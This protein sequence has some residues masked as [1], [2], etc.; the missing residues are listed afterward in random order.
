MLSPAVPGPALADPAW[1]AFV[2]DLVDRV[3]RLP[4]EGTLTV[5]APE[6]MARP[7]KPRV[8]LV[9][10]VLGQR[11]TM[12]PAW[13][14]LTREGDLVRARAV[15]DDPDL[16]FPLNDE[17]RAAL[18]ALGWRRGGPTDGPGVQRWF[19][20]DLPNGPYLPLEDARAAAVAVA[21]T[22]AGVFGVSDPGVLVV[23]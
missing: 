7:C 4:D 14:S 3:R 1:A 6:S 9:Q 18:A 21:S 11:Y 17:E 8:G 5:S 20:D 23:A 15:S 19:P 22:H 13:V 12:T 2:D 10:R 16:G